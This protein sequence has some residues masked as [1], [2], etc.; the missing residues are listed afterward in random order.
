MAI[1]ASG[2]SAAKNNLSKK[3]KNKVFLGSGLPTSEW[4][5]ETQI[6]APSNTKTINSG[7]LAQNRIWVHKSAGKYYF[8]CHIGA[9]SK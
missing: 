2:A 8:S 4:N 9:A 6:V 5:L 7:L 3:I 1:W